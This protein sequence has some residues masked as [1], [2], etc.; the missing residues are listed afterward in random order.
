MVTLPMFSL[1]DLEQGSSGLAGEPLAIREPVQDGDARSIYESTGLHGPLPLGPLALIFP[2]SP[3]ADLNAL[4]VDIAA[5][6]LLEEITVAGNP[7]AIVD[8]KRRLRA[9]EQAGVQP[10]YRRLREDIDPRNYVWARNGERRDLTKGQKAFADAGLSSFS[11]P[12]RPGYAGR[13][14]NFPVLLP[15]AAEDTATPQARRCTASPQSRPL[16]RQ[17]NGGGLTL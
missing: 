15:P 1:E 13:R 4:A 7:P 10:V 12:G 6:G 2:D 11:G 16:N 14:T 9:C 5:N 3:E 17:E 8:G